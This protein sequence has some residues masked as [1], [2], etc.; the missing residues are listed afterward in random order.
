[1]PP[2]ILTILFLTPGKIW[3][4]LPIRISAVIAVFA[5]FYTVAYPVLSSSLNSGSCIFDN[6]ILGLTPIFSSALKLAVSPFYEIVYQY[7]DL[8]TYAMVGTQADRYLHL[9][10]DQS[11]NA[12]TYTYCSHAYDSASSSIF[13]SI[14]ALTPADLLMRGYASGKQIL[15]LGFQFWNGVI[16][17]PWQTIVLIPTDNFLTLF[18]QYS[19]PLLGIFQHS[20]IYLSIFTT[21]LIGILNLR[22]AI[23]IFLGILYFTFYPGIQFIPRHFYH[24]EFIS[25]WI[26]GF[27]I[28]HTLDIKQFRRAF[29]HSRKTLLNGMIRSGAVIG[30]LC[31]LGVLIFLI[32]RHFQERNI[33]K[34]VTTYESSEKKI[35]VKSTAEITQG[36]DLIYV[37]PWPIHEKI[38]QYAT[39]KMLLIEFGGK[40]CVGNEVKFTLEYHFDDR[41]PAAFNITKEDVAPVFSNGQKTLVYTPVFHS[42][43]FSFKGIRVQSNQK[44]CVGNIYQVTSLDDYPLWIFLKLP[45]NWRQ[46][47]AYQRL[48]TP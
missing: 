40:H 24:L 32:A 43:Y 18:Y 9:D 15:N 7:N 5:V 12:A 22:F 33:E 46:L 34:L 14:I 20:G 44:A 23:F 35:L 21:F 26:L 16:Q 4:H 37:N 17:S 41:L 8:L 10:L 11:I 19:R 31:F 36:T 29:K 45:P 25:L 38:K 28:Y 2:V 47:P 39:G 30:G 1:L 42:Q 3:D 27:L 6:P 13:K 48:Q